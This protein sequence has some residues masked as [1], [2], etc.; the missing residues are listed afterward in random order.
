MS[1]WLDKVKDTAKSAQQMAEK[2]A[3][4]VSKLANNDKVKSA[5]GN[6]K[7]HGGK[8]DNYIRK[9]KININFYPGQS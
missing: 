8:L 3:K 7:D 2:S 4:D 9:E 6:L 5:I 1:N